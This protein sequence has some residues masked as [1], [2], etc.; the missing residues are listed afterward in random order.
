MTKFCCTSSIFLSLALAGFAK[1]PALDGFS[2]GN[3]NAPTGN[4]WDPAR[5]VNCVGN[6]ALNKEM[7]RATFTSF[8]DMES[9]RKILPEFSKYVLSLNGDWK[10]NWVKKPQDRPQNFYKTD[11]DVSGWDTIPVPSN[12]NIVGLSE[13]GNGHHKYGLPIYVNQPVV[14]EHKVQVGDWKLGVMRV[15]ADKR[16]LTYEYPNEVGS[17]VKEV[18][19]PADWDGREIFIAFD[20]V[21]SFFYLWVNGQYVGF[22]KNS[23][24]PAR[25][26]ISKLVKAGETA[27]IAVEVYRHS[28]GS[29]LEAQDMFRLPG[30]FRD[31]SIYSTP[32]TQIRDLVAKPKGDVMN[33][34]VDI[35]NFDSACEDCEIVCSL[36]PQT[37]LYSDD[38]AKNPAAVVTVPAGTLK[39]GENKE[40][41]T[42]KMHIE[43][44]L[45]WS[46]EEP[47]LYLLT[48]ELKKGGETLEVVSAQVGFCEVE[49]RK[50]Q[51]DEYGKTGDYFY[52]NG[53]TVKLKGVN[54]HES[55]P[56]RG[57]A[58][59][60]KDM[61]DEIKLMKRANIN[62]VRN[63]HYPDAP[64]WY[65]LCNKYGI[66]LEDEA[67][68]ESHEYY[69]G[70]ASLSHPVE[71]RAAHVAR[72][73]EMVHRN[74]NQPSV[75][76]WSLGNEAG[77]GQNFSAAYTEIKTFDTT[78][79]V[80][81]E[82]NNAIVDMGSN[83]YPS[84][85]WVIGTARGDSGRKYPFHISEYAHSMGNAMGNLKDYW[86]AIET[87]NYIVGG[88]IWDWIDQ[89][90]YNWD[91]ETGTRYLAYGGQFG[92]FPNDGQF[93]MN[94]I[95]FGDHSPKPQYFEVKKVY[96]NVGVKALD[97]ETGTVSI[98]NKNYFVSL[99]EY[100]VAWELNENGK[101]IAAG[102][103]DV[104]TILPRNEKIVKLPIAGTPF[105][106]DAEYFVTL[107]FKL[108]NDRYWAPAGY[109]Q[110]AEQ[111]LI[112]PA[113]AKPSL[114]EKSQK[115]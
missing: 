64:Y 37:E 84:V 44:P 110:M 5:D 10:F 91:A 14:F 13:K 30:I 85:G 83:Q 1:M 33:V 46:A 48:A 20:G 59:T 17:Y 89:S 24:D 31:V 62:H 54:R 94:G 65:Y 82:R 41:P 74:V 77:P 2:Y 27:R 43:N 66:Y 53:K 6:L 47:N 29:F 75:V 112:R 32:K 21:D 88:A 58:L 115:R 68:I 109:V 93:V 26:D 101:Q 69:Y 45:R 70:D 55:H 49:I 56:E 92:D 57:H 40:L 12:W 35:R 80:Q 79:P 105:K 67:N 100:E 8:P 73:M 11:F 97:N 72:V 106:A 113:T 108:K 103:L 15:P 87:S 71:W 18:A 99:D 42:L 60:R 98:F 36:F 114:L 86:D 90:I 78:R 76:I 104:G 34:T 52:V 9:A 102:T 25:F 96:Q 63:S 61:E 3:S 4:E 81:Y 38:F 23:R 16:R 22:S 28:D 111:I 107:S 51:V 19:V 7:P 39:A 50:N 95:I